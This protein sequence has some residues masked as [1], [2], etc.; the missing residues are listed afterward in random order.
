MERMK[1]CIR[2]IWDT[3]KRLNMVN[4]SRRMRE[5]IERGRQYLRDEIIAKQCLQTNKDKQHAKKLSEPQIRYMLKK[6][7]NDT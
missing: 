5:D 4:W 2:D 1:Q 6:K 7:K 3:V